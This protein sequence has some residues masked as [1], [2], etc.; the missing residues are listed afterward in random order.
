[1]Y[2]YGRKPKSIPLQ[3]TLSMGVRII[4]AAI[5]ALVTIS[6]C[7]KDFASDWAGTYDGSSGNNTVQRVVITEIDKKAIKLELQTL[8]LGSY[9]TFATIANGKLTNA[10]TLNVDEDGT[11]Y[12]ETDPYH[13]AGTGNLSGTT[14]TIAGQATNK[15]DAS[16]VKQYYFSGNR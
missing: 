8:V 5:I 12:G 2:Y 4:A 3:K 16:D 7:N 11:I 10:T 6:G 1:M 15:N 9:Y 14:L 13:F